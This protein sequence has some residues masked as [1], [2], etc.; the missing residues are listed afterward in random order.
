MPAIKNADR[1]KNKGKVIVDSNIRSHAN[2]P[3]VVKKVEDAKEALSKIK[4][5]DYLK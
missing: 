4:L 3:F 2:D 1:E 5:P